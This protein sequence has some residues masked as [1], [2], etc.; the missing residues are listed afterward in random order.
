MAKKRKTPKPS[1]P[2]PKVKQDHLEVILDSKVVQINAPVADLEA[3][4][5]A[6]E[7]AQ[8]PHKHELDPLVTV[9]EEILEGVDPGIGGDLRQLVKGVETGRLDRTVTTQ[10]VVEAAQWGTAQL[11]PLPEDQRSG[12]TVTI[13]GNYASKSL[14]R[15]NLRVE[16]LPHNV[17]QGLEVSFKPEST[18][19]APRA[20]FA[21]IT[22]DNDQWVLTKVW[23]GPILPPELV[24][25]PCLGRPTLSR[26]VTPD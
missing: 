15:G 13:S 9:A 1:L 5:R 7:T 14:T 4:E 8:E 10:E 17:D 2:L 23:R 12:Q 25:Y 20:S 16:V 11:E 6:L 21:E 3:L 18:Y 24:Q 22:Y 26:E 19:I